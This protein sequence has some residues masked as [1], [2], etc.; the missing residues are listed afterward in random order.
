M[1]YIQLRVNLTGARIYKHQKQKERGKEYPN[2]AIMHFL[3]SWW[4]HFRYLLKT[5]FTLNQKI[6][7]GYQFP[8]LRFSLTKISFKTSLMTCSENESNG[9]LLSFESKIWTM[10]WHLNIVKKWSKLELINS[11]S[12]NAVINHLLKRI[13]RLTNNFRSYLRLN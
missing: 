12:W 7:F 13:K 3:S 5:W 2:L 6:Y 4:V 9:K 8:K 11:V 10:L 1:N